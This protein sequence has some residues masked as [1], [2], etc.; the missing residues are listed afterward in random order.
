MSVRGRL[1]EWIEERFGVSALAY[2]VPSHANRL[3]YL[4]GGIT[5]GS[6]VMLVVTGVY[7]AQQYDPVPSEAHASVV[8]RD[9]C[10]DR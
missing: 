6:F 3:P 4:L 7:L 5:A 2:P 1:G 9:C 10:T 8:A